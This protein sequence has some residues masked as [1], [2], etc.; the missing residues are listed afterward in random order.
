MLSDV[1]LPGG[2]NGFEIFEQIR[3]KR[4]NLKC[5]F[6]SGYAQLPGH[7]MPEGTEIL[8]KPV[9]MNELAAKMRQAIDA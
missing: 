6:M 8:S 4:P 2:M 9:S 7:V 5:L 1:V 3:Q